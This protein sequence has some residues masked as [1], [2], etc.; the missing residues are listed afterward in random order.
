MLG[1]PLFNV[2]EEIQRFRKI[3]ILKSVCPLRHT[4]PLRES[5]EGKL[6]SKTV[7][8]KFVRGGLT[9]SVSYGIPLLLR[10]DL[11]WEL[12]TLNQET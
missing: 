1:L 10:T 4:C 11:M 6:F 9:S 12:K 5:S 2:K 3:R 8:N 7:R